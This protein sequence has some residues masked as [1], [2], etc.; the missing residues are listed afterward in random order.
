[1]RPWRLSMVS[2]WADGSPLDESRPPDG[3]PHGKT[4]REGAPLDAAGIIPPREPSPPPP[5][6]VPQ[7]QVVPM[8]QQ[9]QASP[10]KASTGTTPKPAAGQNMGGAKQATPNKAK[11]AGK[12]VKAA[13]PGRKPRAQASSTPGAR[14]TPVAAR[15]APGAN[16]SQPAPPST[17]QQSTPAAAPSQPS[18]FLQQPPISQQ[19]PHPAAGRPLEQLQLTGA[20]LGQVSAQAPTHLVSSQLNSLPA[21]HNHG[22]N[23]GPPHIGHGP[24]PGSYE[25]IRVS[26]PIPNASS[27]AHPSV[28]ASYFRA[29]SAVAATS[30]IRGPNVPHGKVHPTRQPGLHA[31][32]VPSTSLPTSLPP[33]FAMPSPHSG[34]K[35]PHPIATPPHAMGA[36]IAPGAPHPSGIM[37]Q[38]SLSAGGMP[39]PQQT[40]WSHPGPMQ[41]PMGGPLAGMLQ[42]PG[43][44]YPAS[45]V[46]M[47]GA[48]PP[49]MPIISGFSGPLPLGTMGGLQ[50]GPLIRPPGPAGGQPPTPSTPQSASNGAAGAAMAHSVADLLALIQGVQSLPEEQRPQ[51]LE[52]DLKQGVLNVYPNR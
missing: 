38:T 35:H 10:A 4:A 6:T 33:P 49:G 25:A 15:A 12:Q 51:R 37:G 18:Q 26:A 44:P 32:K 11:S 2:S 47:Q 19:Q 36:P 16:M 5:I 17:A 7:R 3:I 48:H 45:M 41:P 8:Q 29:Q 27:N 52:V 23:G 20:P 40:G 9:A 30:P 43:M 24:R 22:S 31:F 42:P 39:K 1:M 34:P 14:K 21:H 28:P 46:G 13:T 50:A